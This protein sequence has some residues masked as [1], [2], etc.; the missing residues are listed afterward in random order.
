M[1]YDAVA[2]LPNC[3]AGTTVVLMIAGNDITGAGVRGLGCKV[4]G[5]GYKVRVQ[6]LGFG[7][8]IVL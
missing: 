4:G 6:W 2:S 5:P 7:L 8:G 3:G 1:L